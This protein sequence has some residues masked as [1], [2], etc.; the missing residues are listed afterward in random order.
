MEICG[1]CATLKS[2]RDQFEWAERGMYLLFF[3]IGQLSTMKTYYQYLHFMS[4]EDFIVKAL[5][6]HWNQQS[7]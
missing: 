2:R 1:I 3:L 6:E 7:S 5:Q 4:F